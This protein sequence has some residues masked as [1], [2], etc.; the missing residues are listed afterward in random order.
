MITSVNLTEKE[1]KHRAYP[2]GIVGKRKN[3]AHFG[4]FMEEGSGRRALD[5]M[6]T[7]EQ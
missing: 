4:N 2:R 1:F 5:R 6:E 3:C 7:A